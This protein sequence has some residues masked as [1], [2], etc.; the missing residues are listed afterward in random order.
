MTGDQCFTDKEFEDFSNRYPNL[1]ITGKANDL[2]K[3]T[4]VLQHVKDTHQ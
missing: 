2:Y 3:M 4:E 1:E